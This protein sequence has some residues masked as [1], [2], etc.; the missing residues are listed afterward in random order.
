MRT[1]P[2]KRAGSRRAACRGLSLRCSYRLGDDAMRGPCATGL[3]ARWSV[4]RQQL[5]LRVRALAAGNVPG[6]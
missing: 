4:H 6:P 2:R 1:A 5:R 3:L